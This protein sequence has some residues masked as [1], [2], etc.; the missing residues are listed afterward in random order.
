MIG[1]TDLIILMDYILRLFITNDIMP[2]STD[3]RSNI[4][5]YSIAYITMGYSI[6]YITILAEPWL[7]WPNVS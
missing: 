4:M 5:G 6:A 1:N 7:A 3:I 2:L